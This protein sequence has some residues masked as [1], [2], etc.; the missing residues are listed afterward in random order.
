MKNM[1]TIITIPQETIIS[2]I[3]L[4]RGKKVMFDKDLADLYDVEAKVLNQ[5]VKRNKERFPEDF[6]FQLDKKET[7]IWRGEYLRSQFVTLRY[8]PATASFLPR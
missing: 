2:R 1:N 3:F 5:A 4:I 6:V 7:E 8:H